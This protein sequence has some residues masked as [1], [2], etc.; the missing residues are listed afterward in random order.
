MMGNMYAIWQIA[1]DMDRER[2]KEAKLS[3]LLNKVRKANQ[4]EKRAR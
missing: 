3:R 1:H 2:A 4:N